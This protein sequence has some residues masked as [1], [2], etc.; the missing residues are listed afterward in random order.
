MPKY[1]RDRCSSN[2][3]LYWENITPPVENSKTKVYYVIRETKLKLQ[4]E[5]Q[6]KSFNHRTRKSDTELSNVF[7]ENKYK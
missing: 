7:F 6:N 4:Y 5:N 3:I 2:N 1:P